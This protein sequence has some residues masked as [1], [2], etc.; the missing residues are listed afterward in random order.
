MQIKGWHYL[1]I[2]N[3]PVNGD[4]LMN[5]NLMVEYKQR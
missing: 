5:V 2:A 4:I 3:M 1:D